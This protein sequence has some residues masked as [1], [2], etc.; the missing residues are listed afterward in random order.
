[1]GIYDREYYRDE[2]LEGPSSSN[3]LP[4]VTNLVIINVVF[5]VLDI[6][7]PDHW[8]MRS[9]EASPDSLVRPWL[10]WQLVS[11]G[12]AHSYL[13]KWH[14]ISNMFGLWMFGRDVESVYGRREILRIYLVVAFLGGLVWAARTCLTVP[15]SDW[16][17]HALVGASGAVTAIILLFCFL[18]PRRTVLLMFVIPTPAWVLG[19]LI[20]VTNLLGMQMPSDSQNVAYD[21]HLVGAAFGFAYYRFGWNLGRF[22]PQFALPSRW[23]RKHP[24]LKVHNPDEGPEALDDE[25]DRILDKVSREGIQSLT[26]RERR[27]L[28]DYSRRMRQKHH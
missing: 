14:I 16:E 11:Y 8:L 19:V 25:A 3:G 6:F 28:E 2:Q 26:S 12:F 22:T 17:R 10:W 4:M 23:L 1:M 21:V 27:V 7:S 13:D 15:S 24:R 20:V 18:F 5:Y 9:M